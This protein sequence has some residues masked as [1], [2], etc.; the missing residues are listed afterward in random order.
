MAHP[1]QRPHPAAAFFALVL[2]VALGPFGCGSDS[3]TQPPAP[4]V[5]PLAGVPLNDSP[6]NTMIRFDAAYEKQA[7]SGYENL[8]T[9]DFQF[10]FSGIS[11]PALAA[12]YGTSWGNDEESES[13]RNLFAAA[14]VIMLDGVAGAPVIAD[15]D[16]PDSLTAYYKVVTVSS[17]A[18]TIEIPGGDG[19]FVESPQDFYLVRGDRATLDASQERAPIAGTSTAGR[20][21][22]AIHQLR[23]S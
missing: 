19:F 22:P 2:A 15:P 20:T 14:S 7:Q 6:A 18:L 23:A 12:Q 16:V 4:V 13:A 11:D 5:D 1:G 8:F 21:S 9:S 17:L 3:T 10:L